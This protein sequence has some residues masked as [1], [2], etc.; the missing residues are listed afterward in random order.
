MAA[1]RENGA[2]VRIRR[3]GDAAAGEHDIC[4]GDVERSRRAA[5][6]RSRRRRRRGEMRGAGD[7]GGETAGIIAGGDR[8]GVLGGID[9]GDDTNSA[10]SKPELV[11]DDLRE[12][13]AVPL[14][15]RDRGDMHADRAERIDR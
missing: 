6:R 2:I 14:A 3:A 4:G 10:G 8:P 9:L 5:A 12:H 13:G 1:S 15:L 7:R 11:G